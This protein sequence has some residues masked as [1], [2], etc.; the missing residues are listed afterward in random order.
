[1]LETVRP[2]IV[3]PTHWN[4]FFAPLTEALPLNRRFVD[5]AP[6]SLREL[7]RRCDDIDAHFVVLDGYES[8]ILGAFTSPT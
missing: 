8:I 2:S 7:K 1:M 3:V 4:D 6:S 5:D